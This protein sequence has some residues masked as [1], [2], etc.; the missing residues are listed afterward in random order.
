MKEDNCSYQK[1]M[2]WEK[3][4]GDSVMH[5]DY[6]GMKKA[7]NGLLDE[8]QKLQSH[9]EGCQE[10]YKLQTEAHHDVSQ[11]CEKLE[12]EN[13]KL[14]EEI[15]VVKELAETFGWFEASIMK[16][17][18]EAIREIATGNCFVPQECLNKILEVLGE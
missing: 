11:R 8:N 9:L 16:E 15:A 3:L 10:G 2:G 12:E 14:R 17:R 4:G 18:L 5:N 13:Q 7:F 1:K 6:E